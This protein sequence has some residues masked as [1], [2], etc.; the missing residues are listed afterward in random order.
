MERALPATQACC[1]RRVD[2]CPEYPNP[3]H[4]DLRR[5]N[6]QHGGG[7]ENRCLEFGSRSKHTLLS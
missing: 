3:S 2:I 1:L 6:V 7:L 5:G 4:P